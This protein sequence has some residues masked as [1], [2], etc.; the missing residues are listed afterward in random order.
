MTSLNNL[1]EA[2]DKWP[3][4]P[5]I[6]KDDTQAKVK[7]ILYQAQV[8][9]FKTNLLTDIEIGKIVE[10]NKLD[11]QKMEE[12]VPLDQKKSQFVL[13]DELQKS[14]LAHEQE[15]EKAIHVAYIE[16]AK[17]QIDR[18]QIRADFVQKASAVIVT[19]YTG[20]LTLVFKADSTSLPARG[21]A[22]AIFLGL[23][24]VF[25]AIYFAFVTPPEDLPHPKS[26]NLLELKQRRRLDRYILWSR[27]PA[28]QR[29][30][31]L[32]LSVICLGAGVMFLPAPFLKIQD[33]VVFLMAFVALIFVF[34]LPGI[35]WVG[36]W[37]VSKIEKP[38]K[39]LFKTSEQGKAD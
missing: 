30:Y 31:F 39:E 37:L 3:P 19:L 33:W 36:S 18:I 7:E 38:I 26:T 12:N 28:L 14:I 21:I 27:A 23:A 16:I 13:E 1:S 6:D 34:I 5:L 15:L 20:V 32:Q 24:V 2:D 29:R 9:V 8:D 11:H 22:P 35:V 25:S 10:S 17:G 4:L